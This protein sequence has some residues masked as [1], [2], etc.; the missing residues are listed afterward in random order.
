MIRTRFLH[1]VFFALARQKKLMDC[2]CNL[3]SFLTR[4]TRIVVSR[5]QDSR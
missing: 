2:F 1:N 4:F 5:L 3:S